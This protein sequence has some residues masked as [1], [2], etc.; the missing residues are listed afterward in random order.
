MIGLTHVLGGP[1]VPMAAERSQATSGTADPDSWLIDLL[2]GVMTGTGLRITDELALS[3]PGVAACVQVISDDLAKVPMILFRRTA[4]GGREHA[5]DHPLYHL[6][7]YRPAPWLTSFAFRKALFTT[8]AVAGNGYARVQRTPGGQVQQLTNTARASVT[9]RWAY[10]SEPFFDL[11]LPGSGVLQGLGYQDVVH[12]PYRGSVEYGM[13]GGIYGR[14]PIQMHREAIGLAV[15][16]EQF[17]ARFFRNGAR[18]TA[19]VEMDSKFNDDAVANRFRRQIE[20]VLTGV[21]NAGKIAVLELG[22]KLKQWSAN[23]DESQL[24]EIRKQQ[25]GQFATMYR[26][27]PHKIGILDNATFTNI[28]SQSIEFVGDCLVPLAAMGEQQLELALLTPAELEEYFIEIDL[29]GLQRGDMVSRYRAY[30]IGRQ[31]GW[32][33]ADDVRASENMNKLPGGQGEHYLEP[34]NMVK[35]DDNTATP[36]PEDGPPHSRNRKPAPAT[37]PA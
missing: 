33:S 20:N 5:K 21:D 34:L 29:D 16:T 11:S 32:L 13:N 6:L 19:V 9:Q 4:D 25:A 18:P 12:F 23:N 24:V 10:D 3:V 22:M 26:M 8:A 36:T 1:A 27:P 37:T 31:W 14:S 15:A 17:A 7:R 30:S 28:E 35:A 2:G